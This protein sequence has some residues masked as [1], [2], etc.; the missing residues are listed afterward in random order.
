MSLPISKSQAIKACQWLK[1]CWG[2]E[3]RAAVFSPF[4]VDHICAI[5]CQETA[6]FWLPLIDKLTPAE[7][8]A[9]CV[10][11]ASG[12]ASGTSRSA[13]PRN[14]A[15]F[16]AKCGREFA[17]ALIAEA[18]KTRALRG[19][20]PK[21]WVYKGYGIFQYDLQF[22]LTDEQFFRL[23]MWHD[24]RKCLDRCLLEL[25]RTY[26][27]HGTIEEAIRAY[28]GAGSAA[29]EYRNNV[30]FYAKISAAVK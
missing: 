19:W 10:L 8:L 5:A 16:T 15:A 25:R 24:F 14:T 28:N 23:Q 20:G 7:I 6:Y 12:D 9:R 22:V 30:L 2:D 26:A 3:I 11:D 17:D 18:N 27:K 1:A 29:V 21:Q 13:F 4:T